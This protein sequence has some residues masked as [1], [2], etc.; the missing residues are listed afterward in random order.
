MAMKA[1]AAAKTSG[2]LLGWSPKAFSM[3][4][5]PDE[6]VMSVLRYSEGTWCEERR[7]G[8]GW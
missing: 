8:K 2:S 7:G 3:V 1:A 5:E 4:T 6:R